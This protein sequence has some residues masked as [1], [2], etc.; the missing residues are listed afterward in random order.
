[1]CGWIL[2]K[3]NERLC[4]P[5]VRPVVAATDDWFAAHKAGVAGESAAGKS[6]TVRVAVRAGTVEKVSKRK[7]PACQQA[8]GKSVAVAP[9]SPEFRRFRSGLAPG[10]D[11]GRQAGTCPG[12]RG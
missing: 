4:N 1:M 10:D 5:D 8:G 6:D 7:G 2:Q 9:D 12:G 11:R 3:A